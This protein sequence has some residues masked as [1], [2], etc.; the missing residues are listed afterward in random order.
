MKKI[1]FALAVVAMIVSAG[2]AVADDA[3]GDTNVINGTLTMMDGSYCLITDMSGD[4]H[5]LVV[6]EHSAIDGDLVPGDTVEA[7]VDG[8]YLKTIH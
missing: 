2:T 8:D 4:E 1:T 7:Y 6:D 5:A 3:A